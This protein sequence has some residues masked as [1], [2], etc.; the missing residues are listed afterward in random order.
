MLCLWSLHIA[1]YSSTGKGCQ[2][3]SWSDEQENLSFPCPRSRLRI[4]SREAGS[5]VPSRV[6]LLILH[7]TRRLN[8]VLTRGIPPAF[9]DGAHILYPS[10]TIGSIPTL[11]GYVIIA[12][13]WRSLPRVRRHRASSPQGSFSNSLNKYGVNSFSAE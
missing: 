13:R 9:H 6:S 12:Y 7:T 3:C 1:E 2:Y 4:W 11:S 8:L 10:T 5:A